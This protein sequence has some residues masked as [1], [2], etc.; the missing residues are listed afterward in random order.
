MNQPQQVGFDDIPLKGC[1]MT[2][3]LEEEDSKCTLFGKSPEEYDVLTCDDPRLMQFYADVRG[4]SFE[5][6]IPRE[7]ECLNL[8]AYFPTIPIGSRIL[9]TANGKLKYAG[10]G[11][12]DF[13]KNPHIK[14]QDHLKKRLGIPSKT[15]IILLSYGKDQLIEEVWPNRKELYKRISSLGFEAV[16]AINYSVWLEQ[17]HAERLFNMKRGLI[18]FEEMQHYGINAIPH[19]YWYYKKDLLRWA[20]WL[21]SYPKVKMVAINLQT[22]RSPKLWLQTLEEMRFLLSLIKHKITFIISGPSTPSRIKDIKDVFA[23]YSL[24]N[25]SCALKSSSGQLIETSKD[26]A[27]YTYLP[28]FPKNRLMKRNIMTYENLASGIYDKKIPIQLGGD[29]N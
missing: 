7:V 18:T 16:T 11:L 3:L 1:L 19:I 5:N 21:N 2:S 9:F 14:T 15:K 26:N 29:G 24:T 28:E 12:N 27:I 10:V 17:P 13:I 6:L 22:E 4:F 23:N 20:K 25:T 8:P